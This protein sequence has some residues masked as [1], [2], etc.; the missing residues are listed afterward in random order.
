MTHTKLTALT[1]LGRRS[2]R[3]ANLKRRVLMGTTEEGGSVVLGPLR[4]P[5][6]H[7]YDLQKAI[8]GIRMKCLDLSILR[9]DRA[10]FCQH[11]FLLKQR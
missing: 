7:L 10:N 3:E 2:S 9:F 11:Y 8:E 1:E 4:V 5:W 6:V